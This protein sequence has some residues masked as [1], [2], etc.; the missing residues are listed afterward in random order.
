MFIPA[1]NA[2]RY[3]WEI[4]DRDIAQFMIPGCRDIRI[5][6]IADFRFDKSKGAVYVV[7]EEAVFRR[8]IYQKLILDGKKGIGYRPGRTGDEV[9]LKFSGGE[10]FITGQ[11]MAGNTDA[12]ARR[13]T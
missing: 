3:L 7:V 13:Q 9:S 1:I 8:K 11:R 4:S 10:R 12:G 2:E 5:N 6:C